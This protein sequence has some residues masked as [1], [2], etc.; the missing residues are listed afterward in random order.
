VTDLSDGDRLKLIRKAFADCGQEPTDDEIATQFRYE[1]GRALDGKKAPKGDQALPR[2]GKAV[3]RR[4]ARSVP[5]DE[6][7]PDV[8]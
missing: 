3:R 8:R 4:A 6:G 5:G 7:V 1:T 2:L